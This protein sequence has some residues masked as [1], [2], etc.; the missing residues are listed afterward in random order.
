MGNRNCINDVIIRYWEDYFFMDIPL[1]TWLFI[2]N[3]IGLASFDY[4][5]YS[6]LSEILSLNLIK[7]I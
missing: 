4:I 5:N 1:N 7:K 2:S 6:L 3:S